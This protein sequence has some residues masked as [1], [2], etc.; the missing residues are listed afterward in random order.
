MLGLPDAGAGRPS[1]IAERAGVV[2]WTVKTVVR[3]FSKSKP[4]VGLAAFRGLLEKRHGP[5]HVAGDLGAL[6]KQVA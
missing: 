5:M 1:E 4:T 6:E 3:N 2:H